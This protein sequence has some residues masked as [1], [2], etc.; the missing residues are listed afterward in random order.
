MDNDEP[1]HIPITDA[2]D[3]HT[4]QPR[5]TGAAVEAYL[6]EARALGLKTVRIIHGRGTG[7]QR[8]IV[9]RLLAQS[10]LVDSYRDAP[11]E[12]GGWGATTVI[13]R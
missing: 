4:V 7:T 1:I 8:A 10:P 9:R 11:P 6:E 12:L 13:L 5:E 3:L 2:F